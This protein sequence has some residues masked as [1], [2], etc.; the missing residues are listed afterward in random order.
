MGNLVVVAARRPWDSL[1][2]LEHVRAV[3]A[4]EVTSQKS[5]KYSMECCA[6]SR[7]LAKFRQSRLSQA[8]KNQLL[9]IGPPT[10]IHGQA[11]YYKWSSDAQDS[12]ES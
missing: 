5:G 1:G 12:E 3:T 9:R 4:P 11:Q 6:K 2:D 8:T 7:Q 10:A